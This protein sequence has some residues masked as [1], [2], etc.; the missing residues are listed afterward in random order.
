MP[1][2]LFFD[3]ETTGMAKWKLPAVDP[4]QPKIV[5][6]GAVLR[7]DETKE[8][9]ATIDTIIKPN[10][11]VIDP[12]AAAVHG[13]SQERAEREGRDH[14]EV[15]D[16]FIDL[17]EQANT[18][19]AHNMRFDSLILRQA[20]HVYADGQAS[21]R[22]SSAEIYATLS[23]ILDNLHPRCTMLAAVPVVKILHQNPKYPTDYKWPKLEECV[24]YFFDEKL[25]GAHAALVD[26]R[27]C[28]RVYDQLERLDAFSRPT[29]R[30]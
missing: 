29:A 23:R 28:I 26:V 5:E 15:L 22:F 16:D 10:G 24:R 30:V 14:D 21:E 6:L 17:M 19:V 25:D 12:G 20:L 27:A 4:S 1:A 9:I 18:I 2:T 13:I 7:D 11:W 8:E 3:T